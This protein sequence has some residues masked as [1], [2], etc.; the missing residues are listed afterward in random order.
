[1][2][3]ILSIF[4]R[5]KILSAQFLIIK[6][7]CVVLVLSQ[8]LSF[9]ACAIMPQQL[10]RDVEQSNVWHY[11]DIFYIDAADTED[12]NDDFIAFYARE[13][14]ESDIIE[15]RF[16]FLDCQHLN[17]LNLVIAMD[18]SAGGDKR[19]LADV[20]SDIEWDIL[21]TAASSQTTVINTFHSG[22]KQISHNMLIDADN[23]AIIVKIFGLSS[24]VR[25]KDMR[26]Q[27]FIA[28]SDSQQVIDSTPPIF[29]G[30][31]EKPAKAP[32]ILA[33]WDSM[34]A[35]T[36][37]QALR[38]WNGAHTG[39]MGNRHGL[40]F[41]LEAVQDTSISIALL[42]LNTPF[43]LSTL[44]YLGVLPTI[45]QL[46][47]SGLL[48]LPD[49]AIGD[50]ALHQIIL[51]ENRKK[52]RSFG[53]YNSQAA[54]LSDR[55]ILGK[56]KLLFANL[57]DKKH[58]ISWQG[59]R[60]IPLP[61]SS[62]QN[63]IGDFKDDWEIG[64]TSH[65]IISLNMKKSLLAAALSEDPGDLIVAGGSIPDSSWADS[66]YA[67]PA[68]RYIK[69]HPW[70]HALDFNDMIVHSTISASEN[71]LECSSLICQSEL[72]NE[73]TIDDAEN[74]EINKQLTYLRDQV[75]DEIFSLPENRMRDSAISAYSIM[76][77]PAQSI[78]DLRFQTKH[79]R[80]IGYSIEASRWAEERATTSSCLIDVDWDDQNECILSNKEL[81]II[82]ELDDGNLVYASGNT[83]AGPIQWIA[84]SSF[85][86]IG[87]SDPT[88]WILQNSP[89]NEP[90]EIMNAFMDS[91]ID[92]SP[93]KVVVSASSITLRS[94][95]DSIQK[96]F[97]INDNVLEI[98][99]LQNQPV[100]SKILLAVD[101][102]ARFS[103]G[104]TDKYIKQIHLNPSD[105]SWGSSA[106]SRLNI[107][108]MGTGYTINTFL[109]S[110]L[111]IRKPEDPNLYYLPGHFL[112]LTSALISL[113][114]SRYFRLEI[115]AQ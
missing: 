19:L 6:F 81:F 88:V 52:I 44:D 64:K 54:Y 86:A 5:I 50:A 18:Y 83:R 1:M 112:P 99:Y 3:E 25:L 41:L 71:P 47:S 62:H 23:D 113:E 101:P 93:Y 90:L 42:D 95:D 97:L 58:I 38:H 26:F 30:Q 11:D 8:L 2:I 51:Q 36:P 73:H 68:F 114:P 53:L 29:M 92:D 21:L 102:E 72:N 100:Q 105:L 108:I 89:N 14:P 22:I 96:T 46:Q 74:L 20:D 75:K 109:D 40:Y 56:Y 66:S 12:P 80:D 79:I 103:P 57:K 24:Q 32:L 82:I 39:P 43:S 60:L 63:D 77:Q 59:S 17:D 111:W 84:P 15:M 48:T 65:N 107:N 31:I 7:I 9:S 67:L 33:F 35:S 34:P 106:D 45:S 85:Y 76:I 78:D 91:N 94:Q 110:Y 37:A 55:S 49:T 10:V 70:I 104:W 69:N 28:D 98:T 4:E 27:I 87:L 13:N 115:Q 16:D 61:D